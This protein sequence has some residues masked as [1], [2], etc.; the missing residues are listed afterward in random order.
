[1][2]RVFSSLNSFLFIFG[3]WFFFSDNFS[4]VAVHFHLQRHTGY[5]MLQV[6]VPCTLIVSCSWVS[7]WIDPQAVPARVSLGKNFCERREVDDDATKQNDNLY[8]SR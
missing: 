5:F 4:V 3:L 7:F 1:M 6:Y 8:F 2:F